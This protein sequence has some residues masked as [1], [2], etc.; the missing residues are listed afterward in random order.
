MITDP[1]VTAQT[2]KAQHLQ[3]RGI[4]VFL[5][6]L[7]FLIITPSEISRKKSVLFLWTLSVLESNY[8]L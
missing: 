8:V 3:C 6:F 7:P 1:T 2:L 5:F 4:V